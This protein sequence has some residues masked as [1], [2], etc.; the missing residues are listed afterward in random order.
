MQETQDTTPVIVCDHVTLAY[1]RNEVVHDA[2]LEIRRGTFLPFIGPNGAGKTTL[3]RAILGLIKPRRG[4][5]H[6]PFHRS[7]PGYVPQQKAIDRLYPVSTRQ[8][9]AM[10]LY[11]HL[12]WWRRPSRAQQETVQRLLEEFRLAEHAEKTFGELSG[13]MRQK[14][15]I[16]RALAGGSE[17]LVM[18]EPSS[19]LDEESENDL[20]EHL[21][22]LARKEGKTVLIA[23]HGLNHISRLAPT[24]CM[25]S[26]GR[27]RLVDSQTAVID[28]GDAH[29]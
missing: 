18:D 19:E 1:G 21:V 24:L 4:R 5:I 12:G 16:A 20:L 7:P 14:A 2:C 15:F 13:G 28:R 22:R 17:V 9:V 10:G 25:V 6:T 26:H 27:V 8:I 29:A 23:H 11:P 3:L